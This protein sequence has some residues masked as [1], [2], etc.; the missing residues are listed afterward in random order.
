MK[1]NSYKYKDYEA[2]LATKNEENNLYHAIRSTDINKTRIL[3]SYIYIKVN[4]FKQNLYLNFDSIIYN[5]SNDNSTENHNN[6]IR[7]VISDNLYYNRKPLNNW[8]NSNC[9][10]I[11]FFTLFPYINNGYIAF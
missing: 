8:V 5:F 6:E 1:N 7:L 11:I 4:K 2:N 3:S 9:Y 10:P